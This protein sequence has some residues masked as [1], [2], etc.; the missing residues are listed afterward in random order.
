MQNYVGFRIEFV[1]EGGTI[2]SSITVCIYVLADSV[3]HFYLQFLV[4][5][6]LNM[7]NTVLIQTQWLN[8]NV[9]PPCL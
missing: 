6:N 1:G 5:A 2:F 8:F 4:T 7:N 3:L 9:T